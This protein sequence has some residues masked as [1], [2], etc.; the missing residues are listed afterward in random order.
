M[1]FA[2]DSSSSLRSQLDRSE[3]VRLVILV[4]LNLDKFHYSHLPPLKPAYPS[5]FA[6][7]SGVLLPP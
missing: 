3:N 1:R 6:D 4:D 7:D 5:T 2:L